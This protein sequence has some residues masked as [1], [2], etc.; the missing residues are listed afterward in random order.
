MPFYFL[1]IITFAASYFILNILETVILKPL[2]HKGAVRIG[3]YFPLLIRLNSIVQKAGAE[4]SQ[5][6][7]CFYIPFTGEACN[8][9]IA[10]LKDKAFVDNTA[11]K[12][13]LQKKNTAGHTALQAGMAKDKNSKPPVSDKHR[14]V[15]KKEISNEN[16]EAFKDFRDLLTLKAYSQGTVKT[17]CNEFGIFLQTIGKVA[18]DSLPAERLKDY[19]LYCHRDLKLSENTIHSRMN[20]LKFYY[21]QVLKREKFFWEIPRPKKPLQIPKMFS[22]E[23]IEKILKAA[24]NLKHKT[25]LLLCYSSG[26]RVSEVVSLTVSAID[27]KR[28]IINILSAKGKKDRVVPLSKTTLKYLKDYYKMYKPQ[29]YFFEGQYEGEAWSSRSLQKVLDNAKKKAGINRPGS[30]HALRHS[31]ATHLLDKGTDITYIQKILGHNDLKTTLRYLHVT[32]RDLTKIESPIED[33]D[34]E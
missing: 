16:K 17:Y 22:K 32:I 24:E 14:P 2:I 30:I 33:L 3:I 4:W 6:N 23:D 7:K 9:L 13:F 8:K 12:E 10:A 20:A 21:E 19:L 18:A 11:L 34:V 27:S 28:M 25:A 15:E 5:T 26:L 29:K 1:L 31:Y